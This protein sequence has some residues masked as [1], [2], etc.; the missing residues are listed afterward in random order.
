MPRGGLGYAVRSPKRGR[1]SQQHTTPERADL[2]ASTRVPMIGLAGLLNLL[3]VVAK[4][5][6]SHA[7]PSDGGASPCPTKLPLL[8]PPSL[9]RP[10]P[11]IWTQLPHPNRQRLLWL[12]SQLLER[13]LRLPTAID[14]ECNDESDNCATAG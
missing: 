6:A 10:A 13:Q 4:I 9:S 7:A 3:D 14:K 2:T 1:F 8:S 5:Q 11:P 12:L